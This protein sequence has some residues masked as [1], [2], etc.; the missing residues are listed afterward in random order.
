MAKS[1]KMRYNPYWYQGLD[2]VEEDPKFSNVDQ[3]IDM[4]GHAI[5]NLK[6]PPVND[7]DA[8]TK[9]YVDDAIAA[10]GAGPG[11]GPLQASQIQSTA[12]AQIQAVN[13]QEAINEISTEAAFKNSANTFQETTTFSKPAK[14]AAGVTPTDPEDLATIAKVN[15]LMSTIQAAGV[16]VDQTTPLTNLTGSNVQET[17]KQTDTILSQIK[18]SLN[19]VG[20]YDVGQSLVLEVAG[21]AAL[22]GIVANQELPAPSAANKNMYLLI[23][24]GGTGAGGAGKPPAI[25]FN[26]GDIVYSN[27]TAWNKL[28]TSIARSA[29]TADQITSTATQQITAT[30]VQ[31]AINQLSAKAAFKN[32]A[33]TFEEVNTFNKA[34]KLGAGANVVN[35]DDIVN[36]GKIKQLIAAI[37]V[38]AAG[39][40]V[41][42]TTPL[43][44]LTGANVQEALRQADDLFSELSDILVENTSLIGTYNAT[45]NLVVE[46]LVGTPPTGVGGVVAGSALPAPSDDNKGMYVVVTVAGNGSGSAPNVA[47]SVG[48]VIVSTGTTWK[49]IA[50][51]APIATLTATQVT[52]TP[53]QGVTAANVQ[54]ALSQLASKRPTVTAADVSATIPDL[55]GGNVQ[56]VLTD[57]AAKIKKNTSDITAN[58]AND[59]LISNKV[60]AIDGR[61]NNLSAKQV[62]FDN[63]SIALPGTD[64]NTVHKAIE[65]VNTKIS[66]PGSVNATNVTFTSTQ[67]ITGTNVAAALDELKTNADNLGNTYVTK[68]G[69][70][71]T[72]ELNAGGNGISNLKTPAADTDAVNK[73]YVDDAGA[74]YVTKSNG[75]IDTDLDANNKKIVKL[76][77]PT[78]DTDAANQGY[79]KQQL[80]AYVAKDGGVLIS[81]LNASNQKITNLGNPDP[82]SDKDAVNVKYV[83]DTYLPKVGAVLGGD[84]DAN[85]K[86][87]IQLPTP[88]DQ[89]DAATKDYVDVKGRDYL[90][91]VNG[92]LGG[93][94]SA[95]THKITNLKDGA[96]LGDAVNKGQLDAAIQ[97]LSGQL[98]GKLTFIGTYNANTNKIADVNPAIS[99]LFPEYV[100]GNNLPQDNS[101]F[102]NNF[103]I[104]TVAGT[105]S[106]DAPNVAMN[107]G[108]LI[109]ST[110]GSGWSHIP[111]G[112]TTSASNVGINNIPQ[113]PGASNVQTALESLATRPAGAA[114]AATTTFNPTGSVAATNVQDAIAELDTEK[115]NVSDVVTL[116]TNQTIT[117]T[118]TINEP[119]FVPQGGS[120]FV[121]KR[122]GDNQAYFQV[123]SGNATHAYLGFGSNARKGAF[124]LIN[125]TNITGHPA[126]FE[127]NTV[128]KYDSDKPID[129]DFDIIYKRYAYNAFV[130]RD[131]TQTIDG[132]KY[133]LKP[134]SIEGVEFGTSITGNRPP[135]RFDFLSDDLVKDA[136]GNVTGNRAP[137]R[138]NL[139]EFRDRGAVTRVSGFT[140]NQTHSSNIARGTTHFVLKY[141]NADIE[142]LWFRLSFRSGVSGVKCFVQGN[143]LSFIQ[144][145]GHGEPSPTN[146]GVILEGVANAT[147]DSHAVSRSFGDSRYVQTGNVDQNI[148][149]IKS[150]GTKVRLGR[151]N[152]YASIAPSDNSTKTLYFRDS[153][154]G[155]NN[156][157][158]LN[159]D[160]ACELINLV[161]PRNNYDAAHKKYVDDAVS[162]AGGFTIER[163]TDVNVTSSIMSL[164]GKG[165]MTFSSRLMR[166]ST[167][168]DVLSAL[169]GMKLTL[170][171]P[172]NPGDSTTPALLGGC[173][174]NG[175]EYFKGLPVPV[176]TTLQSGDFKTVAQIDLIRVVP[177]GGVNLPQNDAPIRIG[178]IV[179]KIDG[180]N[181]KLYAV[182]NYNNDVAVPSGTGAFFTVRYEGLPTMTI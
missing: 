147:A 121:I 149:G 3:D 135:S 23:K 74:R 110:A 75:V 92:V 11:G 148:D 132:T 40:T 159:L 102:A 144:S 164:N 1:K 118:K 117:G 175:T 9:K 163:L 46:T 103:L 157:F 170:T 56:E 48:D 97:S 53:I 58:T 25:L 109:Y 82:S 106:G 123:R 24:V 126:F 71:L 181:T 21:S 36:L 90:T 91:K 138:E 55:T 28:F 76:A 142:T 162:R 18:E 150:F 166:D 37:S 77:N 98:T 100:A 7:T 79:V 178:R 86:R 145:Q 114:T 143:K 179:C 99:A 65:A 167:T 95:G 35:D 50:T 165:T 33:N 52:I 61:L 68:T 104:V 96:D 129:G 17:T 87:I 84:L 169:F 108:D 83:K 156:K 153:G 111:L 63:S 26:P 59:I 70:V 47:L 130:S 182:F 29:I 101:K 171:A 67:G 2:F 173:Q 112:T 152:S 14:L 172:W 160:R 13:V 88:V 131:S 113:L 133:F 155:A 80:G 139:I 62:A 10:G 128:C 49:K 154:V 122:D 41:D 39:V 168:Q 43:V 116:T 81:A 42:Q 45:T 73:K 34:P 174:I 44:N 105:G 151:G 60:T 107:I 140:F 15:D 5:I 19:F 30:N 85:N 115:A 127:F 27:G 136:Q 6:S 66:A 93:D 51:A 119:V 94:L 120:A 69:G 72:G 32:I 31:E 161:D 124:Q 57:A 12:T 137:V 20:T 177:T 22:G 134:I 64:I 54:E 16:S 38:D 78:A 125:M 176:D 180:G 158:H 4:N 8:V 146:N 89:S 141:Y